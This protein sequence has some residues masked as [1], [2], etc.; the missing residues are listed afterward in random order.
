MYNLFS[1]NIIGENSIVIVSGSNEKLTPLDVLRAEEMIK[2]SA[3]VIC[4]L[5]VPKE[6]SCSA[7]KL[8]KSHGSKWKT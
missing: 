3:V 2:K 6:T 7:L 8:A 1:C 4:Q 5:E